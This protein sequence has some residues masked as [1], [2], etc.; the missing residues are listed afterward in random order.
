MVVR[1]GATLY[2]LK[3]I[4]NIPKCCNGIADLHK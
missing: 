2:S 3:N 1:I 4:K